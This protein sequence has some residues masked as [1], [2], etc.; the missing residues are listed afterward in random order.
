MG[1]RETDCKKI[2][3]KLTAPVEKGGLKWLIIV[4]MAVLGIMLMLGGRG[5]AETSKIGPGTSNFEEYTKRTEA[6]IKELCERVSG[7]G[8]TSVVVT[9]SGETA[10]AASAG[11]EIYSAP[12]GGIGIVCEGGEDPEVAFRLLSLVSAA[13]DVPT[14]RIYITGAEKDLSVQS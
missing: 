4:I 1:V 7:V 10:V 3:E 6:R 14:S 2:I 5:D 12:I 8:E 9:F 13:C 11:E